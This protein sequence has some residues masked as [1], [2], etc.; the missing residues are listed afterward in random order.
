ME[1]SADPKNKS[2]IRE[3]GTLGRWK[4][5]KYEIRKTEYGTTKVTFVMAV[6]RLDVVG[7]VLKTA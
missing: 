1:L 6:H 7:N 4:L 2:H 3:I 5:R